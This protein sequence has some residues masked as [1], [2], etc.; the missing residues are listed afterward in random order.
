[1]NNMKY[2]THQRFKKPCLRG[3]VNIPALTI[4][5]T[6]ENI[7]VYN[8]K[9]VCFTTSEDAY[10]YF[11]RNDDGQGLRRGKLTRAIQKKLENRSDPLYQTRWD[12][13]WNDLICQKY[14]R[15]DH[16]DHWLWNHDF[17]NAP[18]EDLQYIARLIGVKE[19]SKCN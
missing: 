10:Q 11:A 1:M 4:C 9:P 18:I 19:E 2:I 13:I 3:S 14:K 6:V 12:A 17:F 16:S 5:E 15:T 7:I 8:G